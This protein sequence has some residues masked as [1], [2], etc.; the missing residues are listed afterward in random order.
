MAVPLSVHERGGPAAEDYWTELSD[1]AGFSTQGSRGW[2]LASR[3]RTQ[4]PS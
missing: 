3:R 4:A 1:G 2:C